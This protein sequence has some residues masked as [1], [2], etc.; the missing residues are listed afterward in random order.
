[1]NPFLLQRDFKNIL[2]GAVRHAKR[3]PLY[4][5]R[6]RQRSSELIVIDVLTLTWQRPKSLAK[7]RTFQNPF[8]LLTTLEKLIVV[9]VCTIPVKLT[10]PVNSFSQLLQHAYHNERP[11][12][13]LQNDYIAANSKRKATKNLWILTP[14]VKWLVNCIRW[15]LP[16]NPISLGCLCHFKKT[17]WLFLSTW[18]ARSARCKTKKDHRNSDAMCFIQIVNRFFLFLSRQSF[19]KLSTAFPMIKTLCCLKLQS[20]VPTSN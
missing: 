18:N 9:N 14:A 6:I 3:I 13:D 2:T 16:N 10:I 20:L 19:W 4:S 11:S 7:P 8:T 17:L 1:M 5:T 12:C 15:L